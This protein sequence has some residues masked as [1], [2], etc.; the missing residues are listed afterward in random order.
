MEKC[1]YFQMYLVKIH[2]KYVLVNITPDI[3]VGMWNKDGLR[4]GIFN[5]NTKQN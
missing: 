2:E 5:A 3:H 4:I 1:L